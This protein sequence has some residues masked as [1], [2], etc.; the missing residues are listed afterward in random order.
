M[1][2]IPE[3]VGEPEVLAKK[4][5]RE[6][7]V[8]RY[9][10]PDG[11]VEEYSHWHV[12]N[13]HPSITFPVTVDRHV[14][15]Q[16]EFR[17]GVDRPVLEV[18]GGNRKP[19]QTLEDVARTELLEETG[20]AP[21]ELIL[22]NGEVFPDPASL[23]FPQALFLAKDCVYTGGRKLDY[24]EYIEVE[25]ITLA[26]WFHLVWTGQIKDLKTIA[27][28]MLALPYLGFYLSEAPRPPEFKVG[29]L[30]AI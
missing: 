3:K 4:F 23:T 13:A 9:R 18:S 22:L 11:K 5:G 24:G 17:Y 2:T 25:L 14:V 1:L 27:I 28:T 10:H 20:Y 12:A 15:A 30:K 29:G 21:G 26:R 19:G 16:W 6:L 8:Q 7:R